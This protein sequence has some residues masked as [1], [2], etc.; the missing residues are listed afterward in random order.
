MVNLKNEARW[1]GVSTSYLYSILN[2]SR[3][4]SGRLL[5]EKL[6]PVSGI[7]ADDW[8]NMGRETLRW[9]IEQAYLRRREGK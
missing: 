9:R 2:N 4:P 1:L 8:L 5:K 7:N 6:V 3:I